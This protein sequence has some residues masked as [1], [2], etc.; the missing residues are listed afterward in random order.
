MLSSCLRGVTRLRTRTMKRRPHQ[1]D[2]TSILESLGK[3][4]RQIGAIEVNQE[5][6]QSLRSSSGRRDGLVRSQDLALHEALDQPCDHVSIFLDGKV[7]R[8]EKVKLGLWKV[9]Q[10]GVSTFRRKDHVILSPDDESRRLVL[11]EVGL[12]S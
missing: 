3:R 12:P 7:P 5:F 8:V 4:D 2:G 1:K 6:S 11:S 10:V 9:P